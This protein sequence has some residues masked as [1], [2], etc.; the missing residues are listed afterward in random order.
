M[1]HYVLKHY[2]K[3]NGAEQCVRKKEL[4]ICI[5]YLHFKKPGRYR[6]KKPTKKVII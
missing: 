2:A 1:R 6:K 3:R 5:F 4:Y